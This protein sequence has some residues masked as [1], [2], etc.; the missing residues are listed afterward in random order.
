MKKS[1]KQ[2]KKW[3]ENVTEERNPLK[4]S[5]KVTDDPENFLCSN[6]K[7]WAKGSPAYC[8]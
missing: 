5:T 4:Q 1:E 3:K 2:S 6:E 7:M 8:Y